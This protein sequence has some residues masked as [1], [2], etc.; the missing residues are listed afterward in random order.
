MSLRTCTLWGTVLSGFLAIT[1]A[2]AQRSPGPSRFLRGQVVQ[3]GSGIPVP[4]T[5]IRLISFNGVATA[6]NGDFQLPVPPEL[7]A[8]ELVRLAVDG[9][10]I[11]DPHLGVGGA[12]YLPKQFNNPIQVMVVRGTP[13]ALRNPA[14]IQSLLEQYGHS[15]FFVKAPLTFDDF[16]SSR[17]ASYNI[18]PKKMREEARNWPKYSK[19]DGYNRGL[20]QLALGN[21]S[22]AVS[23]L[24]PSLKSS[25]EALVASALA[26][27]HRGDYVQADELWTQAIGRQPVDPIVLNNLAVTKAKLNQPYD[28]EKL[29]EQALKITERRDPLSLKNVILRNRT[30][31]I[32][33]Q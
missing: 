24:R 21:A 25:D 2:V 28:A 1:P 15:P 29:F 16:L 7:S 5:N 13:D 26:E 19:D 12:L 14:V 10:E 22:D 8:G 33:V 3:S 20:Y 31:L 23:L 6:T 9:W 11:V 27:Y 32:T 18:A 17:A 4:D 30:A